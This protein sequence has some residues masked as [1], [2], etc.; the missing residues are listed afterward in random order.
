M[1]TEL[2]SCLCIDPMVNIEESYRTKEI[3]YKSGVNK[4]IYVYTAD[5]YSDQNWIWNNI[6]PPSLA[7]VTKRGLRIKYSMLV[8]QTWVTTESQFF[9]PNAVTTAGAVILP[10][11]AAAPPAPMYGYGIVPR[12][13]GVQAAASSIELR[14]NG[15]ATSLSSN[16]YACLY[17]HIIPDDD[18]RLYSSE[19]PIQ[20]DDKAKYTTPEYDTLALAWTTFDSKSPF[21]NA[22]YNNIP[23]RGS[24]LWTEVV[25]STVAGAFSYAVYQI[26]LVETLFVS[27]MLYGKMLNDCSGLANINNLILNVRFQDVNRMISVDPLAYVLPNT[28]VFVTTAPSI[29]FTVNGGQ[30]TVNRAGGSNP[31]LLMEYVTQDSILAARMPSTLAY[32]YE[33]LQP[34]ITNVGTWVNTTADASV[35]LQS[36]RLA[37]IP[38]KLYIYAK[39]SKGALTAGQIAQTTPDTF[40]RIKSVSINFNNRVNL[41]NT[42]SEADLYNMAV[43]S[44]ITDTFNEWRY[45]TG[46]VC[47]IDVA[48]YLCLEADECTGQSN[49]YSTLQVTVTLSASPLAYAANTV[50]ISYDAYI[51]TVSPGKAFITP[52]ECQYI[53]TGPSSA[54][55]LALTSNLDKVC[56]QDELPCKALGGNI[57]N[58]AGKLFKSGLRLFGKI[59]P[60][61]LAMAQNLARSAAG[62]GMCGGGVVGGGVVGGS[63]VGGAMM[64]A[65]NRVY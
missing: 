52:S 17:P 5:S 56:H 58:T 42:F 63:T 43:D 53:L 27:P 47:A 19:M 48:K 36:L 51:T 30:V 40:L 6:T 65:R 20:K 3:V 14:L 21:N 12:A 37:S 31:S 7:T 54:Q 10:P 26:E 29:T 38:S 24:Y 60:E 34:Y 32:D 13:C 25:G 15:S 55:V 28:G 16:D 41:L 50:G 4:S 1:N 33:L 11:Q 22:F 59:T 8:A 64:G 39:P 9:L 18:L 57:L 62:D 45:Y 35:T 61:H 49:K 23:S 44:G 46:S 2:E